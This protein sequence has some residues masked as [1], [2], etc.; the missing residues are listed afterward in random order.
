MKRYFLISLLGFKVFAWQPVDINQASKEQLALLPGIGDKLAYAIIQAREK[1]G[2]FSDKNQLLSIE[3]FSKKI[4]SNAEKH[5]YFGQVKSSKKSTPV[6]MPLV[7]INV[8]APPDFKLLVQDILSTQGLSIEMDKSA[9]NR[10]RNSAWLPKLALGFDIENGQ[11][12][13]E[14]K[15]ELK[16]DKRLERF[17]RD[18][19]FMV[20][21]TFDLEKLLFNPNELEVAKVNIKRIEMREEILK[22]VHQYYFSYVRLF[23]SIK[24]PMPVEE[25]QKISLE[26][27][28]IASLLDAMSTK[29]HFGNIIGDN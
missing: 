23:N 18:F 2:A 25:L 7:A 9:G 5:I 28:E 1:H 16:S 10:I 14:N 6:T 20:K 24:N 13:S 19:G 15:K 12:S 8:K 29:N 3:G 27:Q 22:K 11:T 26:M 21:L 17:G 4:L